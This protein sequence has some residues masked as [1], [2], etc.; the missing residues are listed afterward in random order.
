MI[1][2]ALSLAA[3]VL[4]GACDGLMRGVAPDRQGKPSRPSIRPWKTPS[5]GGRRTIARACTEDAEWY[6]PSACHQGRSAITQA[7]KANVGSA[8]TVFASTS[9]RSRRMAIGRTRSGASRSRA[10]WR[11][12]L[13][14][15]VHRH[16]GRQPDGE[17]KIYRDIFNW[18]IPLGRPWR[19][20][21][22][23]DHGR[24]YTHVYSR[25]LV[26]GERTWLTG[27]RC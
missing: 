17:W 1:G 13:G 20:P 6:V 22:R 23:G 5:E 19:R 14:G 25:H 11:G 21:A 8:A 18:D 4:L 27:S 2:R 16:L 12:D 9:P 3:F 10:R 15:E 7:W 26:T 24:S